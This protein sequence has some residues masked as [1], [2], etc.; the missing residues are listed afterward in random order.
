[1][2][3]T[4]LKCQRCG[5]TKDAVRYHQYTSYADEESNWVTLCPPCREENDKYWRDMWDEYYA[6]LL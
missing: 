4:E 5:E 1:M 6:G 2:N 3:S